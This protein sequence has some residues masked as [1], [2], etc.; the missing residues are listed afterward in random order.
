M[1]EINLNWPLVRGEGD[2]GTEGVPKVIASPS[3]NHT[4]I[5]FFIWTVGSNPVLFR[6][7]INHVGR[8]RRGDC[9]YASI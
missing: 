3:E 9:N 8:E 4:R 2:T 7:F 1:I 6:D 5:S